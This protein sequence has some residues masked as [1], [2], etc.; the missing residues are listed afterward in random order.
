MLTIYKNDLTDYEVIIFL[1]TTGNVLDSAG[2]EKFAAYIKQ[3][4]GFVGVHAATDTE[5]EWDWYMQLVG[6]AFGRHPHTQPARLLKSDI[7]HPATA[8]LPEAWERT[9]EWYD[10][11]WISDQVQPLLF[12]EHTSYEGTEMP[13][14]RHPI[15]W[16]HEFDGGRSFYTG[17]GHTHESYTSDSLFIKH[18]INGILWAGHR[19]TN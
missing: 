3:G 9:D 19:T 18:L 17:L 1:N 6:G 11:K 16:F 8:F 13:G 14:T 5:F 7:E 12:I 4:G 2:K 15:A 10:F